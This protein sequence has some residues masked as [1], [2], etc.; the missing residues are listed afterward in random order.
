MEYKFTANFNIEGK[1]V[2]HAMTYSSVDIVKTL[3]RRLKTAF[4]NA[5]GIAIT[6]DE[7]KAK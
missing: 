2:T 4:P 3:E 5:T 7:P 6:L 1:P